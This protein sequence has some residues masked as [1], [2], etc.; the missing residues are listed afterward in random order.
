MAYWFNQNVLDG[1]VNAVGKASAMFGGLLYRGFDQGVIDRTVDGAGFAASGSGETL[2][3]LQT[4]QVRQYAALMF[5][6]AVLIAVVFVLAIG[7]V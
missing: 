1:I 4:G 3:K 7:E 5:G 6:A 2:K